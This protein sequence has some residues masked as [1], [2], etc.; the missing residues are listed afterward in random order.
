M[1]HFVERTYQ[2]TGESYQ[3]FVPSPIG[4][5]FQFS[6]ETIDK[7]KRL[8]ESIAALQGA[9]F[10][11]IN[12]YL[13]RFSAG[14]TSLRDGRSVS[15][16]RLALIGAD[17]PRVDMDARVLLMHS[18]ATKE[19]VEIGCELDTFTIDTIKK[20]S[21]PLKNDKGSA[22]KFRGGASWIG[23][24]NPVDAYY[25]CPPVEEVEPL[26]LALCDF[27]NR[28]DI[29][30]SLQAAVAHVQLCIIHPLSDGNGRTARALVEV[31]LRRRGIVTT[32]APP[33]FLYRLVLEDNDYVGAIKKFEMNEHQLLYDFWI[34][35]NEWAIETVKTLKSHK[36]AFISDC[37]VKLAK[38][39]LADNQAVKKLAMGL[40]A[41][42]I[43]TVDLVAKSFDCSK[44]E[45][46]M[47][48]SC[49]VQAGIC[50]Q[51]KLREPKD[52]AIWDA[53]QVFERLADFD[54]QLFTIKQ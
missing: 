38:V 39:G 52:L 20:M 15:R 10:E 30:A 19:V 26:M 54:K 36:M 8:D 53:P 40:F 51:H 42:P 41:Q 35:A 11:N 47:R 46:N 33:A 3:A 18:E 37:K 9:D 28:D 22:G 7:F 27:I 17:V 5:D 23:G 13:T 43:L 29:P 45:A 49:L 12:H 34:E 25:V 24:T 21:A 14:G 50:Q 1:A 16:K 32:I 44:D 4:A 48:L 31:I 2:P 6:Q